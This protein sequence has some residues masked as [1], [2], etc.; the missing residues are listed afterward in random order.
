MTKTLPSIKVK[1]VNSETGNIFDLMFK[2][3]L[4]DLQRSDYEFGQGVFP[5]A[6]LIMPMLSTGKIMSGQA[7]ETV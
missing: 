1:D 5:L 3:Y 6:L 7:L 4:I 2:N